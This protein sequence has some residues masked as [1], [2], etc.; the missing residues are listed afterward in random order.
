MTIKEQ[1]L[2]Q[3][4]SLLDVTPAKLANTIGVNYL[5]RKTR[6]MVQ[7]VQKQHQALDRLNNYLLA[8]GYKIA[9]VEYDT[10]PKSEKIPEFNSLQ[11]ISEYWEQTQVKAVEDAN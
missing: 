4:A 7:V 6:G 2:T 10:E 1:L 8:H 9:V 5:S 11:D 3:A